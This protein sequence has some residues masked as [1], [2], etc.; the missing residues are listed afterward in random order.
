MRIGTFCAMKDLRW[1]K[2]A[3]LS[4]MRK[5]TDKVQMTTA[6]RSRAQPTPESLAQAPLLHSARLKRAG[7]Q[8]CFG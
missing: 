6:V 8:N 4:M 5:V 3:L 7:L 1:V 2:R